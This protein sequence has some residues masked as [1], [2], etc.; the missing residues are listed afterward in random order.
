VTV[1]GSTNLVNWE[2]LQVVPVVG[3][4][5]LFTDTTASNN[6]IRFYRLSVP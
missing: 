6:P 3:G 1:S 4:T 2:P 5:A